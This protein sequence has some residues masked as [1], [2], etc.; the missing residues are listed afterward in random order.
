MGEI[1]RTIGE[2]GE[3]ISDFFFDLIGWKGTSNLEFSCIDRKKHDCNKHGL[4]FFVTYKCP[5]EN[6]ILETIFVSVKYT[7][8]DGIK[9][10]FVKYAETLIKSSECFIKSQPYSNIVNGFTY[11][12]K[13]VSHLIFWLNH[14]KE[15]D[16][17]VIKSLNNAQQDIKFNFDNIY[18]IDNYKFTFINQAINFTKSLFNNDEKIEFVY[19]STGLN[20]NIDGG[21][22]L[23]GNILPIHLLNSPILTIKVIDSNSQK[24][25]VLFVSDKFE[26]E[27]LKRTLGL[28][29]NLT[30]GWCNKIIIC[31]PDFQAS[32]HN[33]IK[34]R[35][36]MR[37]SENRFSEMVEIKSFN[38]SFKSFEVNKI[39][40]ANPPQE[41]I[42]LFNIETML[43]FGDQIRQ[44]LIQSYIYKPDLQILL[45]RRGVFVGKSS[46]KSTIIPLLTKT[47]ISP[48]EFEFLRHKQNIKDSSERIATENLNIKSG[49]E[50]VEVSQNINFEKVSEYIA[51]KMPNCQLVNTIDTIL[52][53][54]GVLRMPFQLNRQDLTRDWANQKSSHNGE[55]TVKIKEGNDGL[56]IIQIDSV[57]CL[58]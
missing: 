57:V 29:Q 30:S 26:E 6:E 46:D 16:F 2:M 54:N 38:N 12:R 28:A 5:L 52:G 17:S 58:L 33:E 27:A 22:K 9:S 40:N 14:D 44:L 15:D 18:V 47:L 41:S 55:V 21:R 56:G 50:I 34:E 35:V 42:S 24:Q 53:D 11:K 1:S 39:V 45:N 31:F 13:R 32:K 20:E 4:D 23:S 10:N 7:K 51:N 37:F 48:S 19:P 43:P 36:L 49:V 25:L 3:N 8:Q